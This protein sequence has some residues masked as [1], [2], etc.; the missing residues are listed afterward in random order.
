MRLK[1]L[2]AAILVVAMGMSQ[3]TVAM[4]DKKSDAEQK[5]KEAEESLKSKQGEINRIEEQ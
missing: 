5:K 1:K 3:F 4:A 2:I